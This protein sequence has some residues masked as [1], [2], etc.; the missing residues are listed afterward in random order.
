MEEAEVNSESQEAAPHEA[1]N[2]ETPKEQQPPVEDHQERNW[3]ATRQRISDLEKQNREKDELLRKALELQQVHQRPQEVQEEQI[4]MAEYANYGGVQKVAKKTVEPLEKKVQDLEKQLEAQ[5]QRE[6]FNSLKSEYRDFDDIVN[7]ET[8]ALFEEKKPRL[9]SSIAKLGDPYEM[10]VQTYEYI[11]ALGIAD[12]VPEKR[13]QKEAEK[14]IEKNAKTV[15]SPLA[16]DKR[17]M[18][19]AFRMTESE[20]S[21][22]WEEMN[23]FG[24]MASAVPPLS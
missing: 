14:K 3:K 17:P 19:Q 6:L 10:G 5:R 13:R 20:K 18:A 23:H 4:D 8:I 24:S 16:Y 21:K 7:P 2:Q 12:E 22:L 11:K 15:Q 9:A 1:E